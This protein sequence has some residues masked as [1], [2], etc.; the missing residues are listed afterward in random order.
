MSDDKSLIQVHPE[1]EPQIEGV[2]P[3]ETTLSWDTFAGKMG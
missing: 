1:G 3:A 2:Q